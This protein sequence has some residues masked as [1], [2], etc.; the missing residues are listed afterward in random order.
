MPEVCAFLVLM[1]NKSKRT[2]ACLIAFSLLGVIL[3]A[4]PQA[5]FGGQSATV[6]GGHGIEGAGEVIGDSGAS[7][8]TST[9]RLIAVGCENIHD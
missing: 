4:R 5:L 7:D 9:Q 8:V 6:G 2:T 3:I 1:Y